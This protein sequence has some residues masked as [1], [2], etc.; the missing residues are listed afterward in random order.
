M[1]EEPAPV[2][3]P[4]PA[5]AQAK[6]RG[7]VLSP[8]MGSPFPFGGGLDHLRLKASGTSREPAARGVPMP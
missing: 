5:P 6:S 1:K 7:T 8:R 3:S 2:L 4:L